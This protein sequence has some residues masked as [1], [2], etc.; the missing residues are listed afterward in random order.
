M[1]YLLQPSLEKTQFLNTIFNIFQL[2][3]RVLDI[4]VLFLNEVCFHGCFF[5]CVSPTACSCE[6][7]LSPLLHSPISVVSCVSFVYH[8]LILPFAIFSL[9]LLSVFQIYT[10]TH[11]STYT[12]QALNHM[13]ARKGET[14]NELTFLDTQSFNKMLQRKSLKYY[15]CK[16][17]P[18][19]FIPI[20]QK[21]HS[22]NF[23]PMVC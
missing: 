9:G 17:R 1:S 22:C 13:R 8:L 2:T 12:V 4:I 15:I 10:R 21:V 19:W 11:T 23:I 6:R 5:P 14:W 16:P 7:P 18:R 20:M 3:Y